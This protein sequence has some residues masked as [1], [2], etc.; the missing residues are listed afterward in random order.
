M[1]LTKV[2]IM[3][4]TMVQTM[5]LTMVVYVVMSMVVCMEL[6]NLSK[7]G[8]IHSNLRVPKEKRSPEQRNLGCELRD[9]AS[10]L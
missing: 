3:V 5:V 2:V 9:F 8:K 1:T 6:M 4:M 10:P 7:K